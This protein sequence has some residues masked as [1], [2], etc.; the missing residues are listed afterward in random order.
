MAPDADLAS[1]VSAPLPEAPEVISVH[2]EEPA[3]IV[4]ALQLL[5]S[6]AAPVAI[7]LS[8]ESPLAVGRIVSVTEDYG[9]FDFE[10]LGEPLIPAG[11]L[12]FVAVIPGIK[13]Q[14]H[15]QWGGQP[16]PDTP[17][18]RLRAGMPAGLVKYQRRRTERVSAPL[19][20]PFRA[21]LS[22][23]GRLFELGIDDLSL[24]GVGLR[25]GAA[26]ASLLYIGRRLPR[27]RL[28]LGGDL[29]LTVAMD[30]R[31]RRT[32]H[33]YLLGEQF[34]IGCRFISLLPAQESVLREA[35][36]NMT[37]SPTFPD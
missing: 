14:F 25:T 12:L 6:M 21:E 16:F 22:V 23:A 8:P 4:R 10:A 30:V 27:V 17:T 5:V 36:A 3:R 1:R 28:L 35:I 33:S 20:R 37:A 24:G 2:I 32:W 19:G 15:C 18:V 31:S 13:L 34:L 26:Q 11:R 7:Y 9:Y 29:E